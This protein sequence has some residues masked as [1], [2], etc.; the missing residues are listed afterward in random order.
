MPCAEGRVSRSQAIGVCVPGSERAWNASFHLQGF[1]LGAR[2]ALPLA[3]S[4]CEPPLD[5]AGG[6]G[7]L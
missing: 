5:R 4:L 1:V 2:V 6:T 3:P 7:L